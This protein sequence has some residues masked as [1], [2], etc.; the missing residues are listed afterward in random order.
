MKYLKVNEAF[1]D[2]STNKRRELQEF[3]ND[4]LAYLIDDEWSVSVWGFTTSYKIVLLSPRSVK[5]NR[6]HHDDVTWLS[7]KNHIIPFVQMLS[8]RYQV[9]YE[10]SS[11]IIRIEASYS[12]D[13][14]IRSADQLEDLS[15]DMLFYSF[16]IVVKKDDMKHLKMFKESLDEDDKLDYLFE[17]RDFCD[18]SLAYLLDDGYEV[19]VFNDRLSITHIALS[20]PGNNSSD[21]FYWN[22]IKDYYIPFLQ[23]LS[24]RYNLDTYSSRWVESSKA[25]LCNVFF[26]GDQ[27]S[28]C[29]L[30][31]VI[32]DDLPAVAYNGIWGIDV[33]VISKI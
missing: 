3:S 2:E 31:E 8:R 25:K 28:Y 24:R 12:D 7:V 10:G 19:D 14:H 5:R 26:L 18:N 27:S 21:E 23:L 6:V 33:K 13:I 1:N 29:S 11:T 16:S 22:D 20:L 9:G 4:Y 17:L 30:E 32:N 15:D